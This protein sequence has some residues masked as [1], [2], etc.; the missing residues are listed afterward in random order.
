MQPHYV[1]ILK[2]VLYQSTVIDF[3]EW[4]ATDDT[5]MC[6]SARNLIMKIVQIRLC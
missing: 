5:G 6:N 2:N 3:L 4:K 1:R